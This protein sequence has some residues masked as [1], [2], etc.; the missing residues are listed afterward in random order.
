MEGGGGVGVGEGKRE[1][2]RYI[3]CQKSPTIVILNTFVV[4]MVTRKVELRVFF[5]S[6][7]NSQLR[8]RSS[9]CQIECQK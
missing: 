4:Y 9:D 2:K 1:R 7:W 5:M 8:G 3:P 6:E